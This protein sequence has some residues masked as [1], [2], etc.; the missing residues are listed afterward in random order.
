MYFFTRSKT[1]TTLALLS[2]LFVVGAAVSPAQASAP[3]PSAAPAVVKLTDTTT[4]PDQASAT[5]VAQKY[6]HPVVDESKTTET[7]QT[8]ALPDGS[9]QLVTNTLPV[10]VR[11]G[12]EWV[13]VD[14]TLKSAGDV[15]VPAATSVPVQFSA[16]GSGT[17]AK[18]Q[19]STGQ[20][21]T[22][23]WPYGNLPTPSVAGATATYA[24]VLPGVDL[25]LTATVTGMS[26]VLV[27]KNAAAAADPRVT[28]LSLAIGGAAVAAAANGTTVASA[29]DGSKLTSSVPTWW[30]S[31]RQ[32]ADASGPA[33]GDTALPVA[34]SVTA[35]GQVVLRTQ[36]ITGDSG[37]TYPLYID[38]DWTG[39][40]FNY[41]Y[42][43]RGYPNS[44]FVNG[45]TAR[46]VE[47][48]GH[49]SIAN[50]SDGVEHLAR[51]FW[52]M[53]VGGVVGKHILAAQFSVTQVYAGSCAPTGFGVYQLSPSGLAPGQTWNTSPAG[54]WPANPFGSSNTTQGRSGCSPTLP[55]G[56]IGFDATGTVASVA[57]GGQGSLYIGMRALNESVDTGYKEFAQSAS[58]TVTY[59][60]PPNT[61]ANPVFS[62]P[63]RVCGT[64]TSPAGMPGTQPI[65]LQ[66]TVTDADAGTNVNAAFYIVNGTTLAPVAS[67]S[68]PQQAQGTAQV[69]IPANTLGTGFY[70][71]HADA[72][73]NIDLSPGYS[74]YCYFNIVNSPPGVPGVV[75]TSIGTPNVGLPMTVEFTSTPSDG[76]AVFAYWWEPGPTASPS[77]A[78]PVTAVQLGSAIPSSG[79][80]LG[81]VRYVR[82]DASSTNATGVVVAPI[83][84]TSTLW[85]ASYNWAGAVSQNGA[86]YAAAGLYE[87]T[88]SDTDGVSFTAG[89]EWN[90]DFSSSPL[91]SSIAD[92]NVTS[93]GGALGTGH[94]GIDLTATSEVLGAPAT[95]VISLPGYTALYQTISGVPATETNP[96]PAGQIS[97]NR[98]GQ[99]VSLSPNGDPAPSGTVGLYRCVLV[100]APGYF[101]STSP[102]CEG[103]TGTPVL[104]GYIY[105]SVSAMPA[106]IGP[107]AVQLLRCHS[108]P[109]AHTMTIAAACTGSW[110][111]E[112][113]LG[114][115]PSG[116]W[117]LHTGDPLV[118]FTHSFTVSAW[119]NPSSQMLPGRAYTAISQMPYLTRNGLNATF[120]LG[121]NSA[122][123]SSMCVSLSTAGALGATPDCAVGPALP[124]NTWSMV[125][126]I[127]DANN[128]QI[129]LLINDTISPAAVQPH[130]VP[131]TQ[132]ASTDP[133]MVGQGWQ[134]NMPQ[135]QWNGMIDDPAVFP[136]VISSSQLDNLFN[137][138]PPQ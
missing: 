71:W 4:A 102:T 90:T 125:T 54:V 1:V 35:K 18:V 95:P 65:T 51:D 74:Q 105:T 60:T 19:T 37:V 117:P 47:K 29:A 94:D 118:D 77:P 115:L 86:G 123:L 68:W 32:G 83:D 84:A 138:L 66:A 23:S 38:P 61:P 21:V 53:D 120:A 8:S 130:V 109:T 2:S 49:A 25:K 15:L 5:A 104:L 46:A 110:T 56:A 14:V 92:S 76:V 75:Q 70:A 59:N 122:G 124:T 113:V 108:G 33:H 135:E 67:Y 27:V 78:P 9:M 44:A 127:W 63:S 89:H 16:G 34:K 45:A 28:D 11:H 26:E 73:D 96:P 121:V 48:L 58:L 133:L 80:A 134:L 24:S 64:A 52:Q 79:F 81:P 69:T 13:P 6:A 3:S 91:G 39:G 111:L 97:N 85:V 128:Q 50:S 112:A 100:S 40:V 93:E 31:S 20:W 82:P 36:T 12:S 30:D 131:A 41:W 43:D 72:G 62:S 98:L 129:R 114:F 88:S 57:G 106:N 22:E 136:G 42:I 116:T 107:Y 103:A 87:A 10:R 17:M 55:A 126:G 101:A 99:L 119:V 137:Q 7:S 132:V